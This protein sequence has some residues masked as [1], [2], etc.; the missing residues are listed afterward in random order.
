MSYQFYWVKWGKMKQTPKVSKKDLPEELS[1]M[2]NCN[3]Y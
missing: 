3:K 2:G 1:I